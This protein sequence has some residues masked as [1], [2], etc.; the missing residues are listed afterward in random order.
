[1]NARLEEYA[2]NV[3]AINSNYRTLL[4]EYKDKVATRRVDMSL[5]SALQKAEHD[6]F[7]Y[8]PLCEYHDGYGKPTGVWGPRRPGVIQASRLPPP[9]T[10]PFSK[11][12]GGEF[13][14]ISMSKWMELINH[15]DRIDMRHFVPKGQILNQKSTGSCAGEGC[16]GAGM[17]T[18]VASQQTPVKLNG[19]YL[20]HWSSGGYDGGST[21]RDN[22]ALMQ[23]RG[24]ASEAVWPRSH[25]FRPEPSDEAKEDALQYRLKE[26]WNIDDWEEYGTALLLGFA[27]YSW[28]S[29]HSWFATKLLSTSRCEYANSWGEDWADKGFGTLDENRVRYRSYAFRV[30]TEAEV[31]R[32]IRLSLA[33]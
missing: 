22:L 10:K 26:F 12:R 23:E 24:C 27:V 17:C 2:V 31:R 3:E 7:E 6:I 32:R 8:P 11:R 21:L 28:Y 14:L 4:A 18:R 15:P 33:L 5:E 25:G 16:A 20:Y 19:Y 9:I 13:D 30:V 29:G 1:M